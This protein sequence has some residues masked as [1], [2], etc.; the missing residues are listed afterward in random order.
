MGYEEI[1]AGEMKV[2]DAYA[3]L[4]KI[5][6][7]NTSGRYSFCRGV[8]TVAEIVLEFIKNSPTVETVKRG[9]WVDMGNGDIDGIY[10]CCSVCQEEAYF[11]YDARE[12]VHFDYCPHCGAKMDGKEMDGE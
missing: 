9:H 10:H 5:T 6:S 2:I 4:K 11:D 8:Y 3:L 7:I 1:K 12:Y